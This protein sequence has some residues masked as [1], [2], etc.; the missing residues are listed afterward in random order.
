M[1]TK[2]IKVR[3]TFIEELLGT[4]AAD[5]EIHRTYIGGLAPD[6]QSTEEE[7]ASL[8][9]DEVV[10]NAMS[11]FSRDENDKPV[12][13][14]YQIKGLFKDA[15][16]MLGRLKGMTESAQIK[17][18]KKIIDGLIFIFPRKI[19]IIFEGKVGSCQRPLRASTAQG[20]RITLANSETV[21]AGSYID[22]TIKLLDQSLKTAVLEWLKYG[23][24]RGLGQWRNSGKGRFNFEILEE[25]KE[26]AA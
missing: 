10:E 16:S 20:E 18:Y 24:L 8:G 2:D 4:A 15:C 1:E 13:W 26:K 11:V 25:S 23:R 7:V 3:I 9:V 19:P 21:P 17:A 6:A 14:D 12:L 22:V 5:P